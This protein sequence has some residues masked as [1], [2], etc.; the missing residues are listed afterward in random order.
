M[1]T[2]AERTSNTDLNTIDACELRIIIINDYYFRIYAKQLSNA[3]T[4]F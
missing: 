1:R 4:Y 2:R 3:N